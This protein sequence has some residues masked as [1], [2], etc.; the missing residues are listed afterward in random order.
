MVEEP[1]SAIRCPPFRG[2]F[3]LDDHQLSRR[4]LAGL[5]FVAESDDGACD[6]RRS[7]QRLQHREPAA[8]DAPG[9]LHLSV[10]RQQRHRAHLPEV[11]ADGIA[12]LVH[13]AGG[14]VE[15]RFVATL[16]PALQT[17]LL[18]VLVFRF[19]DVDAGVAQR[20]EQL[21]DLFGR[22]DLG[23]KQV[24][25]LV[26]EEI[27][28]LLADDD[29]LLDLVVSLFDRQLP[30]RH[31]VTS[32][33]RLA[34][35]DRRATRGPGRLGTRHAGDCIWRRTIVLGAARPAAVRVRAAVSRRAPRCAEVADRRAT[36]GPGRLGT[37]HA[38]DCIWRRT[39]VLGAA[40]PAAVRVRAAVSR[41]APRCAEE[42]PS[43]VP[44]GPRF[45]RAQPAS[46]PAGGGRSRPCSAS[47]SRS[48]RRLRNSIP[49]VLDARRRHG[50]PFD[51][52]QQLPVLLVQPLAK[53]LGRALGR[54]GRERS[55]DAQDAG[56]LEA[57]QIGGLQAGMSTDWAALRLVH[58]RPEEA[59]LGGQERRLRGADVGLDLRPPRL[60]FP[61][62]LGAEHALGHLRPVL[63]PVHEVA[64]D[65][66]IAD[67]LRHRPHPIE[68]V[69]L[70]LGAREVA[71]GRRAVED[72]VEVRPRRS[73][74]LDVGVP[75]VAPDV[76][77]G[78]VAGGKLDDV[79]LEPVGE[80]QLARPGGGPLAG[81]VG[82]EA[83]QRPRAEAPQQPDMAVGQR[84][85]ARG[86]R[87]ASRPP[88]RPGRGRSSPRREP[89]IPP[90]APPAWSGA[91][92][93]ASG[94][95]RTAASP[96]S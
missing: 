8:L 27:A 70:F 4:A 34:V 85:P 63:D 73:Q 30:A 66:G 94:P 9:N 36:R 57:L 40:R 59:L 67:G 28:A 38:G 87:P 47:R 33:G 82:V 14:E 92:R 2:R 18:L 52:P 45:R 31:P 61:A 42:D 16:G 41:R 91:G 96:A 64:P 56:R 6:R 15:F 58:H 39:I 21:V 60:R 77:V 5:Q 49:P 50:I 48:Y 25:D 11:H 55:R 65:Y 24:V 83:Q 44:R 76:A 35:A 81:R 46:R 43:C 74:A 62:H 88:A 1:R 53:R 17:L 26:E 10:P 51:G 54:H 75:A 7:R 86:R 3:V 37:R 13:R 71:S 80:Q 95:S 68:Q 90:R 93:T 84:G 22:G 78:V 12:G 72:V 23:W 79:H 20:G 69:A 29:Q 32:C 89:R 19:D